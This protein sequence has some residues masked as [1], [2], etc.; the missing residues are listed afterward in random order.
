MIEPL[1]PDARALGDLRLEADL[2]LTISLMEQFRGVSPK[3][4]S[5]SRRRSSVCRRSAQ[6]SGRSA[7]RSHPGIDHRPVP[8]IHRRHS[9][10]VALLERTAPQLEQKHDYVGSSFALMALGLGLRALG[11]VRQGRGHPD[12]STGF[13]GEGR[14]HRQARHDDRNFDG[15]LGKGR[16][17]RGGPIAMR[18]TDVPKR[19]APGLRSCQQFRARR[20]VPSARQIR[21]G[22]DRSRSKHRCRQY[23]RAASVQAND[24][25]AREA[26]RGTSG[27]AGRRDDDVRRSA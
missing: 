12:S 5:D 4:T 17:G 19:P 14:H 18:C 22:E 3:R 8:R 26:K 1:I 11:R 10:G 27:P 20:R 24:R 2:H 15:S 7:D 6:E 25:G 23:A 16:S 13:G 9:R 21:R